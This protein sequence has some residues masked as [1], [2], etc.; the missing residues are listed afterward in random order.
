M[1]KRPTSKAEPGV[2]EMRVEYD[3]TALGPGVRGKHLDAYRDGTNVVLLDSD[4]A[5]VFR[6]SDSVNA[7]LREVITKRGRG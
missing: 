4:V 1:K 3:R 2:R 7:A 5:T 6:D